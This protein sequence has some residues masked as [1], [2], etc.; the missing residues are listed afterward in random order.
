MNERQEWIQAR[1]TFKYDPRMCNL[2]KAKKYY[3]N[4]R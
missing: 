1:F 3:N 2:T 4:N